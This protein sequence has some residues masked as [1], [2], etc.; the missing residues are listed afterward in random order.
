M[1]A[2]A[3]AN[4]SRYRPT[5]AASLSNL[6]IWYAGLD[7]PAEALPVAEEWVATYRE[8]AAANPERHRAD[9]AR[10]L[11]NLAAILSKL[12]RA[13]DAEQIR[14]DAAGLEDSS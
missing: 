1:P 14:R 7:A 5:L 9:L 10:A 2:L 13:S 3:T 12:D 4:P 11:A 6:C 8:L